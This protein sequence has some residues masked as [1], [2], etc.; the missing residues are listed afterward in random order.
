MLEGFS[1][2]TSF[3]VPR[4]DHGN[5][6]HNQAVTLPRLWSRRRFS[7]RFTMEVIDETTGEVRRAE[8]LHLRPADTFT[9]YRAH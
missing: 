6:A 3:R 7:F 1:C 9:V 4:L 2:A 5:E 8:Q